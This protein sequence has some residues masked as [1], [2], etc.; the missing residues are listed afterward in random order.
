MCVGSRADGLLDCEFER[1]LNAL[2]RPAVAAGKNLIGHA[3]NFLLLG[4]EL[5]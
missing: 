3:R 1:G 4:P 2:H 5:V